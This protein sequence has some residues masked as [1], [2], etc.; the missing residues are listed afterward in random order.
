VAWNRVAEFGPRWY[1]IALVVLAM[2]QSWLGGQL[3]VMQLAARPGGLAPRRNFVTRCSVGF[4]FNTRF[5]KC[6][7]LKNWLVPRHSTRNPQRSTK[8]PLF[9][10]INIVESPTAGKNN[11]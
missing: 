3:R 2:P 1:P 8:V 4:S 10:V 7:L 5:E 11:V 9:S 6:S